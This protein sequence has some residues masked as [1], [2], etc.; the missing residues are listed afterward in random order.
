MRALSFTAH[1]QALRCPL[2]PLIL[3]FDPMTP[4]FRLAS[5][6]FPFFIASMAQAYPPESFWRALHLVET[7]GRTGPIL[8]DNGRALGPL[9]IHRGYHADSKIAGDYSR[10]ADLAYSRRVVAAYLKIYAPTAWA[11]GDVHTLARV[12]NGG[13]NGARKSATLNYAGKVRR[14]SLRQ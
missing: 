4:F 5:V 6:A 14:L 11:N 3:A 2:C 10:C 12:H 8:G 1:C 9:Q 7:S 13:P